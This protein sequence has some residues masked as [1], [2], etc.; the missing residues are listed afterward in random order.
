VLYEMF[1]GATPWS[2]DVLMA[3]TR[4]R[5]DFMLPRAVFA[6][7]PSIYDAVQD[8]I[9][10]LGDPD[11]TRRPPTLQA[12]AESQRLRERVIAATASRP[13]TSMRMPTMR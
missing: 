5:E 11:P 9:L 4:R 12:L 10:R 8:H 3:G 13:D 1:T 6:T 7:C 2:R